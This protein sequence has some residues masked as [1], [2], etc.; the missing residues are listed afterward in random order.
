MDNEEADE[1]MTHRS[2]KITTSDTKTTIVNSYQTY[3]LRTA[4]IYNQIYFIHCRS[5]FHDIFCSPAFL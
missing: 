2:K 5:M 1:M 4:H 3:T